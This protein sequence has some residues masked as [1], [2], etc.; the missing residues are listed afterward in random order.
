MKM[1]FIMF[2]LLPSLALLPFFLYSFNIV[3]FCTFFYFTIFGF[4]DTFHN[5]NVIMCDIDIFLLKNILYCY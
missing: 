5:W 4:A 2:I 3:N 1:Y